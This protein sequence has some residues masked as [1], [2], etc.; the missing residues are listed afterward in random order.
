V[1]EPCPTLPSGPGRSP[2]GESI[3]EKYTCEG[4]DRSPEL[5]MADVSDDAAALAVVVDDP[6][7]PVGTFMRR[8]ATTP[9]STDSRST[10]STRS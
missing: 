5:M 10:C 7:A 4:E 3:P 2:H 8:R 9:T 6:D 1:E